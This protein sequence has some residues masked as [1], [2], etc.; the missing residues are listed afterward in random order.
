M[1]WM[2]SPDSLSRGEPIDG[3]PEVL[4]VSALLQL[5]RGLLKSLIDE[6]ALLLVDGADVLK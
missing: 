1:I 3:V 2:R 4:D 6:V 5:A